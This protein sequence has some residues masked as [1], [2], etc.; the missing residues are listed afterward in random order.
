MANYLNKINSYGKIQYSINAEPKS[1]PAFGNSDGQK[2]EQIKELPMMTNNNIGIRTP[3]SYVKTGEQDLPY[4]L[5]AH[6]YK[7]SNG[8]KIVI[9]PK[10]GQTVLRSYVNTGSLNE[11]DNLRGI[12]HYIEHNLFNGSEGLE[13][14]EFFATTDKMGA[15]TNASTGLAE[16][17][18]FI[19]S[20]LLKDEDLENK[21]KIH[22]SMLETP[23]FATDMLEKE[24]GIV[25]SEIN[26]ITSSPDNIAY[27]NTLKNL[28]NIK[29]TSNDV[30]AGTTDNITNLTREDV[31]NY[32]NNNYYPANMVTV[33]SGEVEPEET[34]KLISK[35]F[36][37]NKLP[38]KQR[39]FEKLVP[40]NKPLRQDIISDKTQSSFIVMG[41]AGPKNNDAR[42]KIYTDALSRLMFTSSEAQNIFRPL[43]AEVGAMSEKVLAK[44]EANTAFM[45]MGE[46][47]EAN[48]EKLL[49]QIYSQIEKYKQQPISEEE[50]SIIKRDMKKTFTSMFETSFMINNFV[51]TSL[52]ENNMDAITKYEQIIDEMTAEDIQNAAKEFFDLN[53]TSITVLHPT[54]ANKD[55]ILKNYNQTN[56][57]GF[58]GNLKKKAINTDNIKQYELENNYRVLTYDSEFPDFHENIV[59]KT[60]T[61]IM[62]KNP[63]AIA[64]LNEIL[65]NG[66]KEKT[67]TEFLK[68]A[69]KNGVDIGV[70]A[71]T[72]G[73]LCLL[74]ADAKD[75]NK[76][77]DMLKEL[78]E[79]PAFNQ[80]TFDKAVADVKDRLLRAEKTPGNKLNP[81]LNKTS[82]RKEDVLKGLDTIT[83]E[84]IKLL[85]SD[86][87]NSSSALVT[88]AAPFKKNNELK[89]EVFADL[90]EYKNVKPYNNNIFDDYEPIEETK[91]L[92]E[93][94][95]KSQAKI[96]MAYKYK[97]T[98]N[99]KDA[100]TLDL[101]N[102]ILG[103]SP[104]SRLFND[105]RE[106][107]KLAYAV[108]SKI[109]KTNTT[110][111]IKLSIGT[112]TDNKE[113]GEQSFDNLQKSIN[114]FQYHID[115]IK[116]EKV[117]ED[118]LE[119]AKLALKN[120][121]LTNSER[122][123]E[124][125]LQ[126]MSGGTNFY[127]ADYANQML[128][129]IDKITTDDIYN[130]AQNIFGGKPLYSI[131]AT[132]DTLDYNKEY[133]DSLNDK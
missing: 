16:T 43:N 24:K 5:K 70:F 88:I 80:E 77:N 104:S 73:L 6:F 57:P 117:T 75:Y 63:A 41:F 109:S 20:N 40:T 103:G 23:K 32:F 38:S 46:T 50:L 96:V 99:I 120:S 65:S 116:T 68:Q 128:E 83:L 102:H 115:K 107:Q 48:S 125:S 81:L 123:S 126:I 87:I 76:A 39:H 19:A 78:L 30:I 21:I 61:P 27:N 131:V 42:N 74:E 55:E 82:H 31:V 59:L 51:G 60:E 11:P 108:R 56:Q 36:T 95:N 13:A 37:S 84:D 72:N 35:Y 113:T 18:Y 119:R 122:T 29:T 52:L 94:D 106:K 58:T 86:I 26:M 130:A 111:I 90:S 79:T 53:K 1:E 69:E 28:F 34:M 44:P 85:Y 118:E 89:K 22:A 114:G 12:S 100:A 14:G 62:P 91:V 127:G 110:G 45:I 112:T 4:G 67:Q 71:D 124:K 97:N 49:K 25:N 92:T 33:V 3:I 7:L 10:E 8:Q 54:K 101:L 132:Q 66:T 9:L 17:N 93:T 129:E 98:G 105:L 2:S 121:I 64:I 15:E 47:S 133:L